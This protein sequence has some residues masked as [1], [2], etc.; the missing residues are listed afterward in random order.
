VKY[1]ESTFKCS[2]ICEKTLFFYSLDVEN[3]RP[4][5]TCGD[6]IL[7]EILPYGKDIGNAA[8]ITGGAILFICIMTLWIFFCCRKK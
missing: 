2:G 5:K 1:V 4:L 6:T 7:K 8:I 3:G